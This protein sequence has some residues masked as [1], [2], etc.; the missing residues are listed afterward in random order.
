[1][2]ASKVEKAVF[3]NHQPYRV[4][5]YQRSVTDDLVSRFGSAEQG[6]TNLDLFKSLSQ[7]SFRGGMFQRDFE[8]PEMIAQVMGGWPNNTDN[9]LYPACR[10]YNSVSKQATSNPPLASGV[11][12]WVIFQGSIYYTTRSSVALSPNALFKLSGGTIT[13]I[14][15]PTAAAQALAPLKLTVIGT[16]MY[17]SQGFYFGGTSMLV[18]RFDGVSTF[19]TVGESYADVAVFNGKVYSIYSE[20]GIGQIVDPAA[21]PW[22]HTNIDSNIG[23]RLPTT[24]T[25]D[26][27]CWV[28]FNQTLYLAFKFGLYRYD[29]V[30][31][32]SVID[33]SKNVADANFRCMAVFNGRL[34]YTI[35]DNKL[36]EFDGINIKLLYDFTKSYRI[37]SLSASADRL[38][39]NAQSVSTNSGFWAPD[40]EVDVT[41]NQQIIFAYN[42]VGIFGYDDIST[43][44]GAFSTGVGMVSMPIA[45]QLR[46]I[47]PSV[48]SGTTTD[49]Q[50]CITHN[51]LNENTPS[52]SRF[53]DSFPTYGNTIVAITSAFD[54]GY[55]SVQKCLAGIYLD[56]PGVVDGHSYVQIEAQYFVDGDW[57]EFD[58]IWHSDQQD[59][60]NP[61]NG[62]TNDYYL[63]EQADVDTPALDSY[64]QLFNKVRFK[65]TLTVA[66]S[67]TALAGNPRLK[68]FAFRY[69]IQPRQRKQWLLTLTLDGIDRRKHTTGNFDDTNDEWRTSNFMR[70]NLYD[71]HKSKMPILFY[72]Y[73]FSEVKTASPI[74]IKGTD[75][76][77]VGDAFAIQLDAN[78]VTVPWA[79]RKVLTAVKDANNNK[80]TLTLAHMGYRYPIGASDQFSITAGRQIRKSHAVYIKDIQSE[81][82]IVDENTANSKDPDGSTRGHSDYRSQIVLRLV[83][84]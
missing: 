77:D 65:I 52:A 82:Y 29:G 73:D 42:G 34:Y 4:K 20:N 79:N 69:T 24:G 56:A 19:A 53:D 66:H 43:L 74:E 37:N 18:H 11:F 22:T 46:S 61:A 13:N 7:K 63:F 68:S 47:V 25:L 55:P 49:G 84:V 35:D 28:E 67:A 83:E 12:S 50:Y 70:K 51:L 59:A 80:T 6:D 2:A 26:Y 64:P 75:F 81:P 15:L 71:C 38:W 58:V 1:M 54:C 5:S 23:L 3:I 62:I 48:S 21:T 76:L 40:D 16:S 8:D 17:L 44:Y 36:Y 72:D 32:T 60:S 31:V 41:A 78:D 39:I 33:M 10:I 57:T 9:C 27:Q 45:G 14:A 30:K